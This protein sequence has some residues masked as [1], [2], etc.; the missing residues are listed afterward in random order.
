MRLKMYVYNG[1]T[2]KNLSESVIQR[3]AGRQIN[4]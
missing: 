3:I 2:I 1:E 4:D